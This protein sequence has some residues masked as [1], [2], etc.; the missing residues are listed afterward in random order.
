MGV[1][2]RARSRPWSQAPLRYRRGRRGRVVRFPLERV[3]R[4]AAFPRWRT[5]LLVLCYVALIVLTTAAVWW[6]IASWNLVPLG[7][8]AAVG[9]WAAGPGEGER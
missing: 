8:S 4:E 1:V 7:V 2:A 3:R 5:A 6:G 9:L